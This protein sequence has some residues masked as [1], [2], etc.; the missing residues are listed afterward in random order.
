MLD[1]FTPILQRDK[2]HPNFLATLAPHASGVREVIKNW[3]KGFKDRDGKFVREFQTTY[4]SSFWELY[5]Y[6]VLKELKMEMDFSYSAPD[7][8]SK[9]GI[10]IEATVAN[11]AQ[12][13][14]PE[15]EKNIKTIGRENSFEVFRL[16][17][18]RL[19]NAFVAKVKKFQESY[20]HLN[21]VKDKPFIIAISNYTRQDFNLHG[22]VPL[23]WLLYDVLEKETILK[24][25]GSKVN[26]GLFRSNAFEDVSAVLYSSLATFGKARVLSRVN[27]DITCYA[28]RIKDNFTP[29]KIE[30]NI[31]NYNESLTDGLR[32]FVNPYAR[33]PIDLSAFTNSDMRIFVSDKDGNLNISCHKDGDL[34]MRYIKSVFP[35]KQL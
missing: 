28:I 29:I 15:W 1:L 25:N 27:G 32:L 5:L 2:L 3:A 18:I 30:E 21:H 19:S 16:S 26:L 24:S 12:D 23:Q 34:C 7:F 11:H 6:A 33:V 13:D 4:N 20:S 8:V 22:D 10:V 17:A 9:C 35:K 14:V 31:S